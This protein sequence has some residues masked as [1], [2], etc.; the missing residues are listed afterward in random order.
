MAWIYLVPTVDRTV[1]E[2]AYRRCVP[3]RDLPAGT[4][5]TVGVIA[6]VSGIATRRRVDAAGAA[7]ETE[8]LHADHRW[9]VAPRIILALAHHPVPPGWRCWLLHWPSQRVDVHRGQHGQALPP[10]TWM[11]AALSTCGAARLMLPETRMP[12]SPASMVAQRGAIRSFITR[13]HFG[14]GVQRCDACT[15]GRGLRRQEHIAPAVIDAARWRVQQGGL[16]T[17]AGIDVTCSDQARMSPPNVVITRDRPSSTLSWLNSR[18]SPC[19][20]VTSPALAGGTAPC[21]HDLSAR[22]H[23]LDVAAGFGYTP[24][25]PYNRMSPVRSMAVPAASWSGISVAM[26]SR[27]RSRTNAWPIPIIVLAPTFTQ[28]GVVDLAQEDAL[29]F[30]RQ[31]VRYRQGLGAATARPS[32]AAATPSTHLS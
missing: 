29:L 23:Q 18:M 31:P 3:R 1:A 24:E 11:L 25:P 13:P 14:N 16:R 7:A 21:T 30:L 20:W 17:T 6:S 28:F 2:K 12:A 22:R 26:A 5:S 4:G 15:T 8:D 9:L 27:P 32:A 10:C 19:P